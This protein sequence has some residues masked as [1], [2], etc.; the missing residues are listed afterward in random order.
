MPMIVMG[1]SKRGSIPDF[2]PKNPRGVS[3][4]PPSFFAR[5]YKPKFY[6]TCIA[7]TLCT[8]PSALNLLVPDP[9]PKISIAPPFCV[10]GGVHLG[11]H[12]IG[13][14]TW[15]QRSI[16]NKIRASLLWL[17]GSWLVSAWRLGK[18][19]AMFRKTSC[20]FPTNMNKEINRQI[21]RWTMNK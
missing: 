9:I 10:V 3:F 6:R 19:A 2:P 13:M 7:R 12:L 4:C 8:W 11:Y 20:I 16:Q 5:S 14:G 15:R 21:D 1:M 17:E 18:K